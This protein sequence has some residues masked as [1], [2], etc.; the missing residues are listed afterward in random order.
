MKP[1]PPKAPPYRVICIPIE[2]INFVNINFFGILNYLGKPFIIPIPKPSK[3][4]TQY[5]RPIIII[6]L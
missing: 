3:N 4:P 5:P 6:A 1:T 2:F